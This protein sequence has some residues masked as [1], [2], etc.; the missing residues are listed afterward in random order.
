MLRPVSELGKCYS[1]T[2]P[3]N[4]AS[5]GSIVSCSTNRRTSERTNSWRTTME[6]MSARTQHSR[7]WRSTIGNSSIGPLSRSD[8][9]SGH[10][11]GRYVDP[12]LRPLSYAGLGFVLVGSIVLVGCGGSKSVT[13]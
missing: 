2:S 1:T 6:D 8:D 3:N 4:K 10:S 7:H 11:L 5:F 12:R 13:P 9:L